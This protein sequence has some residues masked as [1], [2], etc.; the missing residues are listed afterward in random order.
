MK[1]REAELETWWMLL[2]F[3]LSFHPWNNN[4]TT[5]IF[6]SSSQPYLPLS[7]SWSFTTEMNLF[8][9]LFPGLLFLLLPLQFETE[10]KPSAL[11]QYQHTGELISARKTPHKHNSKDR[12]RL[13]WLL[14]G[15]L[16]NTRYINSTIGT[17]DAEIKFPLCS[18]LRAIKGFDVGRNVAKPASPYRFLLPV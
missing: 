16:V 2:I 9:H 13:R 12:S 15:M 1:L 18:N 10:P 5:G 8:P 14:P 17:R 3:Y 11:V 7:A 4:P 6:L